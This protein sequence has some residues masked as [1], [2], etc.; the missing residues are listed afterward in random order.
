MHANN[1]RSTQYGGDHGGGVTD[2]KNH[3]ALV[4]HCAKPFRRIAV[5]PRNRPI[6]NAVARPLRRIKPFA[7]NDCLHEGFARRANK[8]GKVEALKLSEPGEDL[9]AL[10]PRFAETQA[11]IEDDLRTI[12]ACG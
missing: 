3:G 8:K 4:V 11:R 1:M 10:P 12:Y 7:R 5:G 9:E 6:T 2:R